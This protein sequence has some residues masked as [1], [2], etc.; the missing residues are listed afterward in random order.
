MELLRGEKYK[1]RRRRFKPEK[2][3]GINSYIVFISVFFLLCMFLSGSVYSEVED[4]DAG[5]P[6]AVDKIEEKNPET[7]VKEESGEPE[8][9]VEIA[10][11]TG[12]RE[13]KEKAAV[14][15]KES[16]IEK[17]QEK[18]VEES[19]APA[20]AQEK[21]DDDVLSPG[22]VSGLL[23]ITEGNFKYKRIPEIKLKSAQSGD[24]SDESLAM[25]EEVIISTEIEVP[26]NGNE[27]KADGFWGIDKK[28]WDTIVIVILLLIIVGVI[29]VLK[30]KS[31][32]R[33][34]NVLRR[35]PGA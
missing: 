8:K 10:E 5:S 34:D 12:K 35:F 2:R 7:S 27:G 25:P 30:A 23:Q 15:A 20:L 11:E 26:E 16:K 33:G 6:S 31:K 17:K 32:D 1:A 13:K 19:P 3:G 9:R 14:A 4:G 21:A 18:K 22:S 28:T 24:Y 29:I